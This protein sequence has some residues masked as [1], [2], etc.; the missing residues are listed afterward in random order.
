MK[1]AAEEKH[2]TLKTWREHL[3][4]HQGV[5][6]CECEFQ[7]GRFRKGQRIGGCGK[8]RCWLC[9]SEKLSG[10]PTKQ[11]QRNGAILAEGLAELSPLSNSSLESRRS[12]SA[13]QLER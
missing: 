13:A 9:H 12:T 5:V 10:M 3:R 6:V 7:A 1:R 11:Q 2:R 4:A 8:S